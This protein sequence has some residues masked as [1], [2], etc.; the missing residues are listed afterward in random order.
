MAG[1]ENR[2][3]SLGK[4]VWRRLPRGLRRAG[5]TRISAALAAR[6]DPVPPARSEGVIVAGEIAGASGLAE[7][8]RI[9]HQV[10][11]D[12]GK[13][14][15]ALP[16][17]LPGFVEM[18]PAPMAPGAALLAVVNAPILPPSLLRLPRGSLR[19]RRVIGFWAWEL[20]AV[21]PVWAEGAKFVHEVWAPSRFTA[22]ALEAV[23][24]GRVRVVPYPIAA[25]DLPAEGERADFGLPDG[26]FVVTTIF[27]LAS[28][29]ARKNPLGAIA[30]FKTA[31]GDRRDVLFVLKLS[32]VEAYAEDLALIRAAIGDAPNILLMTETIS[33][34][35][36]RGLIRASD[37]VLS[38]HRAEGFGLVPATAMLLGRAVVATGWSGNM[39]FMSAETA[40]LVPYR[41]VPAE[42]P[43]GTYAL[44][45]AEWAEPDVAAAAD[46][47]RRLAD[48]AAGRAA[49]AAA[50]RDYARQRIGAAPLLAALEAAGVA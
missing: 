8:A 10:I 13:S 48:D 49:M 35:R 36:L 16:L 15:G 12:H 22:A 40:G 28:S 4:A 21:P 47:L 23:A 33:E 29:M 7:S 41:L 39:D 6:P 34:A 18:A 45:G 2:L 32:H 5:M 50:G 17:G 31:F 19:G 38:L 3:K 14:R 37:V 9:L 1:E 42:D 46:L 26:V 11:A 25:V 44:A 30:A 27:N 43:R 20:P 24:P